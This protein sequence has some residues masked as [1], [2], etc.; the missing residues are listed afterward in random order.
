MPGLE[1][2]EFGIR[3]PSCRER[4]G[5]WLCNIVPGPKW[6][7]SL[8]SRWSRHLSGTERPP[9]QEAGSV[10]P[11]GGILFVLRLRG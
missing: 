11:G 8:E 3:E 6:C 9:G 4:V 5:R 1:G 2:L 7:I 10:W